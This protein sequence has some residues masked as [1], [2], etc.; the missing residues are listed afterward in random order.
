MSLTEHL[1]GIQRLFIQEH[2]EVYWRINT[3]Q[4]LCWNS[5]HILQHLQYSEAVKALR[6]LFTNRLKAPSVQNVKEKVVNERIRLLNISLF[7]NRQALAVIYQGETK[8]SLFSPDFRDESYIQFSLWNL[9]RKVYHPNK[10]QCN[11]SWSP[12]FVGKL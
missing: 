8:L 5:E 2:S 12:R 3:F 11:F 10:H 1:S 4:Q 7:S 9:K 6:R